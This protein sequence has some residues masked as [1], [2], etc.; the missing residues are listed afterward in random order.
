M[1]NFIQYYGPDKSGN[2][3]LPWGQGACSFIDARDIAEA[4]AVV[5]TT[6]GHAGK[7][8]EV[9]GPEALTVAQAAGGRPAGPSITWTYR[10]RP[11]VRRCSI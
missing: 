3:Y 2:I 10:R 5:F 7:A 6:P 11:R 8:Y 9:T 4:A 1:D